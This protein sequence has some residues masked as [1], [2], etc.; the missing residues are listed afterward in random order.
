MSEELII[1]GKGRREWE[2][3][4]DAAVEDMAI[5][6]ALLETSADAI[7]D[8]ADSM[9][10]EINERFRTRTGELFYAKHCEFAAGSRRGRDTPSLGDPAE[11]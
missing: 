9:N 8:I 5:V 11:Q 1:D 2:Q 4:L 10:D 3:A 6:A 7:K